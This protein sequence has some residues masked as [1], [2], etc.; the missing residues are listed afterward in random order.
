MRAVSPLAFLAW[1]AL[2]NVTLQSS[3]SRPLGPV[4]LT[5]LPRHLSASPFSLRHF[6]FAETVR[7]LSH[8]PLLLRSCRIAANSDFRLTAKGPLTLTDIVHQS[9][10]ITAE[11]RDVSIDNS[12]FFLG[13]SDEFKV[14]SSNRAS[15]VRSTFSSKSGSPALA[16]NDVAYA[17]IFACN[18]TRIR[19][20]G[21]V[22]ALAT[23]LTISATIFANASSESGGALWFDGPSLLVVA[24]HAERCRASVAGGAFRIESGEAEIRSAT[25][26]E[27]Y[28]PRGRA[29]STR[30]VL[31]LRAVGFSGDPNDEID[32]EIEGSEVR[33]AMGHID[34]VIDRV[35][36]PSMSPRE[37]QS[38]QDTPTPLATHL[39]YEPRS[40][41]VPVF[42]LVI[43]GVAAVLII[44]AVGVLIGWKMARETHT[45]Y[46]GETEAKDE[47]EMGTVEV[48]SRYKLT[49]LYQTNATSVTE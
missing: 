2:T 45:I 38:P 8:Q 43:I 24:C 21:A 48:K 19:R 14:L 42:V 37:T 1:T 25:F 3:M 49:D 7:I 15:I 36:M 9:G 27:N 20:A 6:H 32:G 46:A 4:H 44:L 22:A 35:L 5:L 40:T 10:S 31:D 47:N 17:D 13:Q 12:A 28:A 18:F 33:F 30:V 23:A 39:I 11:S 16:L 41:A 26:S 34:R 29:I